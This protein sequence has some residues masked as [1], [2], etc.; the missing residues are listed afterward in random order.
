MRGECVGETA[1]LGINRRLLSWKRYG[2]AQSRRGE[3][4]CLSYRSMRS[5]VLFADVVEPHRDFTDIR[6]TRI[7]IVEI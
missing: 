2:F 7:V 4:C 1:R 6:W 5:D 3:L